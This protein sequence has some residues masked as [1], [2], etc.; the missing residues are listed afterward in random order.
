M[1]IPEEPTHAAR[2]KNVPLVV[3]D[4]FSSKGGRTRLFPSNICYFLPLP[5][6]FPT[7]AQECAL[8]IEYPASAA[9]KVTVDNRIIV[10]R[11][12]ELGP[13]GLSCVP[14]TLHR[15]QTFGHNQHHPLA[16]N[17]ALPLDTRS[18]LPSSPP[19]RPLERAASS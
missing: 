10:P 2:S 4:L 5:R 15:R 12:T 19:S 16:R 3:Q 7:I 9:R 11:F 18:H 1:E 17:T 6:S 13:Y 14:S 8:G